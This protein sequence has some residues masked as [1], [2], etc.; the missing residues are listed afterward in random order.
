MPRSLTQQEIL[1]WSEHLHLRYGL[2][3]EP[4]Q[5][6]RLGKRLAGLLVEHQC[7]DYGQ[8]LAK[9]DQADTRHPLSQ[10]VIEAF[11]I[12]ETSWFR[13]PV[14]FAHLEEQLLPQLLDQVRAGQR[15][16][17][18]I[19]CGACSTGQEPYSLAMALLEVHRQLGGRGHCRCLARI[20]ASDLCQPC[21]DQARKGV[22]DQTQVERGLDPAR[23]E[24]YFRPRAGGWALEQQVLELVE[25]RPLN[26]L[27]SWQGLGSFD[28]VL[29]R[30][31]LIYFSPTQKQA[32]LARLP[33][34]VRPGG[35]LFLGWDESAL[36]PESPWQEL[37]Q[38]GCRWFGLPPG[39]LP[40]GRP[41]EGQ[42]EAQP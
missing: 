24:R 26:L 11:T 36:G 14:L 19:W 2:G 20:L 3:L 41:A 22:Y 40:T 29:L 33:Q 23:R 8:L 30:N 16:P 34:V 5:A 35:R 27:G 1:L 18:A 4:R 38:D 28:L 12:P 15:P 32:L 13:D 21:L 31:V 10:A 7:R 39:S 25:F 42:D 37:R 6:S 17:L 9:V